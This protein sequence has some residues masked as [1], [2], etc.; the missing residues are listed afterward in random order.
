MV[1]SFV[2][3]MTNPL[4]GPAVNEEYSQRFNQALAEAG[5]WSKYFLCSGWVRERQAARGRGVS[6]VFFPGGGARTWLPAV[7][8][9][10]AGPQG[11]R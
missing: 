3:R 2:D 5:Q 11:V 7:A 4:Y 9:G 8:A 10:L 1:E 6:G